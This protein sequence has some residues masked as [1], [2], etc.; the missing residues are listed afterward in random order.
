MINKNI[1]NI[2][3]FAISTVIFFVVIVPAY[4]GMGFNNL[5]LTGFVN[6]YYKNKSINGYLITARELNSSVDAEV[7]A[8]E[9][10]PEDYLSK[11]VKA[12]PNKKDIARNINDI[13]TL[14]LQNKLA[15]S[16]F[17][18]VKPSLSNSVEAKQDKKVY[19]ISFN[20]KGDY[21]DF[22]EFVKQFENSLEIYNIKSLNITSG[23]GDTS[24]DEVKY[25]ITAETY[26]ING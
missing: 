17:K 24:F 14:G 12:T 20:A 4:N 5:K 22:F 1:T 2:L 18:F 19:E 25:L 16:D 7:Q 8:F 21:R 15:I 6:E 3:L 10:I 13:Y 9:N 11:I 26:E 23:R